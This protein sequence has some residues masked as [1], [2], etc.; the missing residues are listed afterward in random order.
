[1]T[2]QNWDTGGYLPA[3]PVAPVASLQRRLVPDRCGFG[4]SEIGQTLAL[5]RSA[6]QP[7]S[8]LEFHDPEFR[9]TLNRPG[10]K[11]T[12]LRCCFDASRARRADQRSGERPSLT[13]GWPVAWV[14]R[15]EALRR[16]M[17]LKPTV[18][19]MTACRHR[20]GARRTSISASS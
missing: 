19:A 13:Y 9:Q 20:T 10:R 3:R 6:Q 5:L 4:G 17:P 7:G 1:M 18:E 15:C 2:D 8:A 12:R 11:W 14:G 16:R